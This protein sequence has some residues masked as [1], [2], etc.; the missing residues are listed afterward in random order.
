MQGQWDQLEGKIDPQQFLHVKSLLTIQHEEA[1]WWRNAC[2]LYFQTRSKRP[3]P[4]TLRK[5]DK[6]LAYYQSLEFPFA[7]G[8]HPKW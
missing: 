5:P 4:E 1:V 2:V 3:I 7:P 6:T 8:I